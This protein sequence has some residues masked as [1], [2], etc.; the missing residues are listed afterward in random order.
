[1]RDLP[2]LLDHCKEIFTDELGPIKQFNARL[3]IADSAKPK[4]L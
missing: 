2:V 1:M 4:V 3:S